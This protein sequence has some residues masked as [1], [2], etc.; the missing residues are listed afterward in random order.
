VEVKMMV[1]YGFYG[2]NTF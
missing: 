2:P 1:Y